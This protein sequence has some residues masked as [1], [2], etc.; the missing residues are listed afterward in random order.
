MHTHTKSNIRP[1]NVFY[2]YYVICLSAHR[3]GIKINLHHSPGWLATFVTPPL[4]LLLR[5]SA[6]YT[7]YRGIFKFNPGSM[8]RL[9]S[10]QLETGNVHPKLRLTQQIYL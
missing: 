8:R 4:Q 9:V 3:G 5:N 7:E 10:I 6:E 1:K 2:L